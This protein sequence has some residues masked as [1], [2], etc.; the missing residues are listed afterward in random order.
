MPKHT[1]AEQARLNGA[2]SKG[3]TT[4]TGKIICA[5]SRYIHG[6]R[7]CLGACVTPEDYKASKVLLAD[8]LREYLPRT[9]IECDLVQQLAL[10]EWRK[11][12]FEIMETVL[13]ES[14]FAKENKALLAMERTAE[15]AFVVAMATDNLLMK[16]S[17]LLTYLSERSAQLVRERA[18]I[19]RHL[20]K[21]QKKSK[22]ENPPQAIQIEEVI[23]N[24]DDPKVPTQD[25]AA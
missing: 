19:L 16:A 20:E 7:A 15:P 5:A 22:H 8:L 14:E 24:F 23:G 11:R 13:L 18:A 21:L 10:V 3:P 12:E 1:K 4:R 9:P 17:K 25:E 6:R 2:K